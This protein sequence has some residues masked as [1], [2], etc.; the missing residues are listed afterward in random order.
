M[1]LFLARGPV[2]AAKIGPRGLILAAKIGQGDQF[3]VKIGPP[4]P[5]LG[6]GFWRAVHL[7]VAN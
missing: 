4:G 5:I 1:G 6:E 2:L 3:F 7:R